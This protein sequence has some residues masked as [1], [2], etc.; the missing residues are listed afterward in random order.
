[1][2]QMINEKELSTTQRSEGPSA[3]RADTVKESSKLPLV[4][5]VIG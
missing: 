3:L 5:V 2:H 1:M 4:V